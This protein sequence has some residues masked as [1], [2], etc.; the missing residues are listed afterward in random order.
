MISIDTATRRARLVARHHLARS[1]ASAVQATTDVVALHSSDPITPHLALWARVE[2]YR[3]VD[4]D[5]ELAAEGA[6]WRLH[7][8]RRT[9]WVA[10]AS[11]VGMLDAAVGRDIAVKERKRLMGWVEASRQDAAAWLEGLEGRVIEAVGEHPGIATRDLT[12]ALP[13]LATQIRIG[14]GKWAT[15]TAIAS[16]LLYLMAMELKIA[17]ASPLGSW[18]S[19]QYGWALPGGV[20]EVDAV[21]AQAALVRRYLDRFGPVTTTDV[22]WWSGLTLTRTRRALQDAGAVEVEIESGSAWDL[23]DPD[24]SKASGVALLPGLDPTPMGYKERDWYLGPHEAALF[25]RN[26]NVGPTIWLDGRIVGGWAVDEHG[27]V[28]VGLLEDVGTESEARIAERSESL[29][30][31]LEGTP[32][33]PRFRTPLEKSLMAG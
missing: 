14:S 12:T 5:A 13:E 9:L 10:D 4:L 16:R 30:T 32:I 27:V 6:L 26:G 19:S 20:Q 3:P 24:G 29:T 23:P 15:E 8:M 31:W 18:K 17:R 25:D 11:E 33:T 22:K 21:D 2:G 28:I 7:A 1:A